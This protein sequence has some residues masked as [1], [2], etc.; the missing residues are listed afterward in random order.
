VEKKAANLLYFV[1]KNHSFSDGNKRIAAFLFVWFLEKNGILYR[2][3]GSKK[4]AD[5]AL[6]AL[7]LM[8]A[9]SKPEEKDM[10]IKVVVNLI[11]T[12]N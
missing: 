3:D 10:M 12:K 1:I 8:I 7:T 6:V 4:I 5:N 9:Q 2:P 11:N